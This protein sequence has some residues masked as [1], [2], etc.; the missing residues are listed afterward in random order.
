VYLRF[1]KAKCKVLH[2]VWSNPQYRYRLGS[3]GI[4]RSPA[5][6]DLGVLVNERLGMSQQHALADQKANLNPLRVL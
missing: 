6:K 4:K 1:N 3:E 5:E 2:M